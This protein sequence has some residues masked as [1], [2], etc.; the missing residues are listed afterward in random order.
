MSIRYLKI[1]LLLCVS[2][3]ALIYA[4]QNVA[5]LEQAVG[6][7]AYVMGGQDH[8]A[9][10]NSVVP[11][12]TQPI[13]HWAALLIV[14]TGEF[15]AGLITGKGAL[16]L[17]K[18]RTASAADF[19]K[20]KT[21]GVLGCGIAVVTWFGLFMVVGSTVFQMWQTQIGDGSFRG[22]FYIVMSSG[23]VMLFVNTREH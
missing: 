8:V 7:F 15:S 21:L 1:V 13:F 5:N 16:N 4:I 6:S 3:Q 10:P 14:L 12:L 22:A 20:A 9:Y 2:F 23:L 11:A 19:E 17:W 18:E